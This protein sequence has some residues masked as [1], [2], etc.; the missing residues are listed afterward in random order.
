MQAFDGFE[1]GGELSAGD[2]GGGPVGAEDAVPA[3]FEAVRGEGGRDGEIAGVPIKGRIASVG[4]GAGDD[5]LG[6]DEEPV[7]CGSGGAE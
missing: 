4:G 7:G 6:A 3:A 5:E 2:A 1:V